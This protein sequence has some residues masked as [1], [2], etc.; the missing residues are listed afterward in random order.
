M[1]NPREQILQTATRLFAAQGYLNTGI[2]QLIAESDVA[3]RTFYHHFPSKEHVAAEYIDDTSKRWLVMLS[4]G[5]E[6]RRT[7]S[8]VVRGIFE[9]VEQLAKDTKYR[10]CSM[11]NMAAEFAQSNSAM[12]A[13]VKRAK[14]A[15]NAWLVERL[16]AVSVSSATARQ[17]DVL[18]EGA[19]VSG[20]AHLDL[21]PVRTAMN[22]AL[23]L[24]QK[25]EAE[26]SSRSA[27]ARKG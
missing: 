12:R 10:G 14:Q 19:L 23:A 11:L 22:A 6:G 16:G 1:G 21:E 2:N 8:G 15:Q 17:I 7:A 13:R 26:T 18:L 3:R 20:G 4:E 27:S 5:T 25:D 24:V 9:V